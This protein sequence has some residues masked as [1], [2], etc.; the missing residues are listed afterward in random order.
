[1]LTPA[2]L[3]A[4]EARAN[5][6]TPGPW[7]QRD[8]DAHM[9]RGPKREVLYAYDAFGGDGLAN[10]AFIAAARADVPA[11]VA[12]VRALRGVLRECD[13]A[14]SEAWRVG[15][16]MSGHPLVHDLMRA[17]ASVPPEKLAAALG[18]DSTPG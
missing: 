12:E 4:I 14:M 5:A 7:T 9:I 17:L 8:V 16:H 15:A 1:M 6:A 10:A 13:A 3:D 2:E 11:L 18:H